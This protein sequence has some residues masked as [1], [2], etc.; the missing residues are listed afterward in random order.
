MSR[1]AGMVNT[2]PAAIDS[3]EDPVVW[4]ML[5]S[6]IVERPRVRKKATARTAMG[7]EA[8]TVRPILSAR[9]TLEAAKTIP[10]IAPSARALG[11]NSAGCWL[12]GTKGWNAGVSEGRG[13]A[14]VAM[15]IPG[16]AESGNDG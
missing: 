2:M 12:G 5:F 6:R 8:L 11:V 1:I 3:P 13:G 10:R 4:T 9:Y 16:R 14:T 15:G 7:I